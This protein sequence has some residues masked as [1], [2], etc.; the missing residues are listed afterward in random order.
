MTKARRG[1][2]CRTCKRSTRSATGYCRD[3]RP[4]R[5]LP[6]VHVLPDGS[7]SFEG[8]TY[9]AAQARRLADALHDAAD[10]GVEL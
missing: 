1:V 9:T 4:E 8:L 6:T 2:R 10:R 5:L 7:V 3:C